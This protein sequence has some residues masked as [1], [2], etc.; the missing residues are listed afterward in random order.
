MQ[1]WEK[2][3]LMCSKRSPPN[4]KCKDPGVFSIPCKIGN[5]FFDTAMLDLRA[6]INVIPRSIYDKLN[7]GELKKTSLIIQLANRSNVYPDGVLEDILVQVNGLVFPTDFY[8]LDMGNA[9][10]NILILLR[11]PFL[12][13]SRAKIGIHRG[14]LTVEF[15][16]E[17]IK[18]SIFDA[19]RFPVDVNHLCALNMIDEL[20]KDVYKLYH[21]DQLLTVL[22]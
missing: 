7:L 22:T 6:S 9:C 3:C 5:I 2:T 13:T 12:K 4:I 19:M 17:V 20:S 10:R 21:E 11:R 1:M 18:F 16:G 15:D 8:V 14:A